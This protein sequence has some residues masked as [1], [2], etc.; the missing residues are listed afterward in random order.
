MKAE[1]GSLWIGAAGAAAGTVLLLLAFLPL[2]LAAG[3][4]PPDGWLARVLPFYTLSF[5]VAALLVPVWVI[6]RLRLWNARR[7]SAEAELACEQALAKLAAHPSL[8][9]WVPLARR[10]RRVDPELLQQWEAR[11]QQLRTDPRRAGHARACLDGQFPD[12]VEI[13]YLD[14]LLAR[15]CCDHLAHVEADLR[16]EGFR[17]GPLPQGIWTEARILDPAALRR[18]YR[19]GGALHFEEMPGAPHQSPEQHLYCAACTSG[20]VFQMGRPFPR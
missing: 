5:T 8:A 18:D 3:G 1:P 17:C 11:Y 20:I 9:H 15:R 6:G 4:I 14:D 16:A 13:D 19:L 10:Y 12:D 7:R 2:L